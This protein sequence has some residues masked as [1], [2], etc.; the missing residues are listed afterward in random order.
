MIK[1]I[2]YKKKIYA[3]IVTPSSLKR[4]GITFFTNNSNWSLYDL[5]LPTISL[6]YELSKI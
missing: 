2:E 6:E 5:I 1:R 3:I 4:N